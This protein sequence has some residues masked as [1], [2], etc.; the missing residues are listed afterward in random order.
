[1][2]QQANGGSYS[3]DAG[4]ASVTLTDNANGYVIADA[5]MLEP[6]GAAPN[7][8]TWNL[9]VPSAGTYNVYARWTA[10]PNRATDAKFTAGDFQLRAVLKRV[11]PHGKNPTKEGPDA[12]SALLNR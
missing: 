2:N 1:V 7:T 12:N 8:A 4:A 9:N 3:F 6:P 11:Q 5:V 10:Y